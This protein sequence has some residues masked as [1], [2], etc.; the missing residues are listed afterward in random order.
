MTKDGIFMSFKYT[1]PKT[2][3]RAVST[4]TKS[5][6]D[7]VRKDQQKYDEYEDQYHDNVDDY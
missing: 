4:D 5:V 6:Q 1:A 7:E 2:Q 3:E